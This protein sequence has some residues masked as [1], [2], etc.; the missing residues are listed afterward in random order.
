MKYRLCAFDE[1]SLAPSWL[2]GAATQ[3]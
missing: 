3:H 2:N 1:H